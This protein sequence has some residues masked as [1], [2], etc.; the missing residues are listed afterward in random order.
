[1]LK[2]L[3]LRSD[4]SLEIYRVPASTV[5]PATS[6]M[7]LTNGIYFMLVDGLL[8]TNSRRPRDNAELRGANFASVP[9]SDVLNGMNLVLS[10]IDFHWGIA[11]S[12]RS[13]LAEIDR[14]KAANAVVRLVLMY[15]AALV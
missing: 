12:I 13:D 7:T 9:S 2:R 10:R 5:S 8:S 14:E 4:N 3:L 6:Q 11:V 1:M 15:V